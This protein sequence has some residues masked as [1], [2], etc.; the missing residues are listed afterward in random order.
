LSTPLAFIQNRVASRRCDRLPYESVH[1]ERRGQEIELLH[2]AAGLGELDRVLVAVPE[3]GLQVG[4][5]LVVDHQLRL[6][7][8][9]QA[10]EHVRRVVGDAVGAALH[11]REPHA[12]ARHV[13]D[14]DVRERAHQ[15][16]VARLEHVL[17]LVRQLVE[18]GGIRPAR[19]AP[20]RLR[21]VGVEHVE[22]EVRLGDVVHEREP[23]TLELGADAA[24]P[25]LVL[26]RGG[27][28]PD[29]VCAH[30]A[31]V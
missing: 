31:K 18:R 7:E 14:D 2:A 24:Y 13:E 8:R 3:L 30:V 1:R 15:H 5:E 17:G 29:G 6:G 23:V 19:G 4:H 27:A 16:R 11:R 10:L 12:G 26:G 28:P 25:G 9:R 20:E 22:D 21:V